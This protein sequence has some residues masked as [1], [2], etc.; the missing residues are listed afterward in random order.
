[1]K[2][3]VMGMNIGDN[4]KE[5]LLL[6]PANNTL[7]GIKSTL[8][9]IAKN[10]GYK[11]IY[12]PIEIDHPEGKSNWCVT[13]EMQ[14]ELIFRNSVVNTKDC[15]TKH[16]QKEHE[17]ELVLKEICIRVC[18]CDVPADGDYSKANSKCDNAAYWASPICSKDTQAQFY[19]D[20][21]DE[22]RRVLLINFAPEQVINAFE[23]AI[24]SL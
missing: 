3:S 17:L 4:G 24:Q 13:L 12:I 5:E 19:K 7:A 10:H 9:E 18:Y 15:I 23:T 16:N 6:N 1:M 20:V 22:L 11:N 14:T 2:I 21:T 8:L